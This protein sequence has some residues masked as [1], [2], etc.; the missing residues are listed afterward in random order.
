MLIQTLSAP[1]K[2]IAVLDKSVNFRYGIFCLFKI[3]I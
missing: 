1:N 3:I 2:S